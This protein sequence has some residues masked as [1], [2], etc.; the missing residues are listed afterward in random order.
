[1]EV[2][3]RGP[4]SRALV[5]F[6]KM[7]ILSNTG[8]KIGSSAVVSRPGTPQTQGPGGQTFLRAL[9]LEEA[10]TS[11]VADSLPQ[12]GLGPGHHLRLYISVVPITCWSRQS[13]H[14]QVWPG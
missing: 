5:P 12:V 3:A 9:P 6:E 11:E 8:L 14:L 10:H 1:M 13:P 7:V 4:M 2:F